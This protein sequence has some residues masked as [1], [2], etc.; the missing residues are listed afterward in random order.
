[1]PSNHWGRKETIIFP[2]HSAI[3]TYGAVLFAVILTGFFVYLRFTFGNTPLQ[4]FYTPIYIRSSVAGSVSASRKD[5]YRLVMIGARGIQPRPATDADVADGNTPEPGTKPLPLALSKSALQAGYALLYLD[6]ERSYIDAPLGAY[7][8]SAIYGGDSLSE[9]YQLPLFFGF[10]SLLLQLPFSIRKD[11]KRRKQMRYGRRLRGTERLTPKEFNRKVQGEGLG[12]KIDGLK[13]ML[14]I[15][16]KAEAQHVQIIA[17]TGGGK[18]TIIMQMLRQIRSRGDSAI[19]YDPA[20]EYTRRFYDPKH[21]IILNPLDRRCPYWGPAEELRTS[22]EADAIAV[23]LFQPPQDKKGEFFFEIPQ[24]IFAYLL[25]YGPTPEELIEWMSNPKEIDNRV[26]RT[27]VAN[28]IDRLSAPATSWRCWRLSAR[29]QE[30]L[31]LLPHKGALATARC[32]RN[33]VVG[34][35][36]GLHLHHLASSRAG[37]ASSTAKRMDRHARAAPPERTESSPET[38]LVCARRA[39]QLAASSP[40]SHCPHREPQKQQSH[41]HGLSGEGSIGSDLRPPGRG[42]A[43]HANDQYFP[44]NQRAECRRV[45]QQGNRQSRN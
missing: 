3:Y 45:G 23:S 32:D 42:H 33:R 39:G 10:L 38:G 30:S 31:R 13:E 22:S 37:G 11:I 1:M 16:A 28:F 41:H 15:P 21:D 12:I 8:K 44:Q 20:L 7:L 24:Q 9:I 14:R 35:T 29:W 27:E 40:V 4:R 43:I 17:D 36:P 18:T 34:N 26:A 25:R 5:Q 6:P 2:P 19:V